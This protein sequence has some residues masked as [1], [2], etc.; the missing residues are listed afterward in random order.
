MR[1]RLVGMLLVAVSVI[2]ILGYGYLIFFTSQSTAILVIKLTAFL[3]ILAI[4]GI[5]GSIGFKLMR[6]KRELPADI[7]RRLS[8]HLYDDL[9]KEDKINREEV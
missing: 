8:S 7:E 3:A 2:T 1:E 4:F 5:L 6:L 9:K